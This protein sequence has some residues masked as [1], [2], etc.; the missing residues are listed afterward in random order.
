MLESAYRVEPV[1]RKRKGHYPTTNKCK[2]EKESLPVSFW[3]PEQGI[4][5]FA[6]QGHE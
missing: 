6:F 4:Q 1:D 5:S 2:A 3:L